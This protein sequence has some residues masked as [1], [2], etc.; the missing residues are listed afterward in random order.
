MVQNWITLK[1]V[2]VGPII[3]FPFGMNM[4]NKQTIWRNKQNLH[5]NKQTN[6]QQ[7]IKINN[8][9]QRCPCKWLLH[10]RLV[11]FVLYVGVFDCLLGV[12]LF[13]SLFVCFFV[14][15]FVCLFVCWGLLKLQIPWDFPG[16]NH[17][18]KTSIGLLVHQFIY[19]SIMQT[20][21]ALYWD[22][23]SNSCQL[24]LALCLIHLFSLIC[25][26]FLLN[27]NK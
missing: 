24:F 6:K 25:P 2:L 26:Q 5:T 19:H 13:L 1:W 8:R 14:R 17:A 15:V 20:Y 27:K 22:Y 3:S 4:V 21:H 12:C 11:V 9:Q 16:Y 18:N 7:A 10:V 23:Y